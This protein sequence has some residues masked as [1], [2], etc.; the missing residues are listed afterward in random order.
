MLRPP[1]GPLTVFVHGL[2]LAPD[3]ARFVVRAGMDTTV[4]FPLHDQAAALA[5]VIVSSSR[6]ERRIED[7][8]LRVEVLAGEDVGEKTQMRPAD[9]RV[10]L[11]GGSVLFNTGRSPA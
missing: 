5:P 11:S 3:S 8:P 4:A 2:G 7:E 6:T 1:L 9:L 10:L